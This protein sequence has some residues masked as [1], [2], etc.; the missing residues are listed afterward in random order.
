[1]KKIIVCIWFLSLIPTAQAQDC[2]A[3]RFYQSGGK[4]CASQMSAVKCVNLDI[5]DSFDF[6]GLEMQFI[7]DMGDGQEE[8]GL[9]IQHCYEKAGRYTA[10]LTVID[11]VTKVVMK[12]ELQVD[13][14][15]RGAFSLTLNEANVMAGEPFTPEYELVYPENYKVKSYYWSYGD[16]RFSCDANPEITYPA[17]NK[18]PLVFN[19]ELV[20]QTD[21]VYLCEQMEIDAKMPDPTGGDLASY[22][23][24]LK[25]DSR[26][27]EDP[28]QFHILRETDKGFD[29]VNSI[30]SIGSGANHYLLVFKGNRL[31]RSD[32]FQVDASA[33]NLSKNNVL[34]AAA[35][36]A[37][38]KKPTYLVPVFFELNTS[39]FSKKMKKNLSRNIDILNEYPFLSVMIGC[40]TH[41]G[42]SF[43]RNIELSRDRSQLIKSYMVAEGIEESRLV[44]GDPTAQRSLINTCV[45]LGCDYEEE[46][47]NRRAD[48]KILGLNNNQ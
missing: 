35:N 33:T 17:S 30:D 13:V 8:N 47:L 6:D 14:Y 31:M 44:L 18:F 36:S 48:F 23:N 9:E 39:G 15:I 16:G 34:K 26:F 4:P 32:A 45:T 37:L 27:L 43:S 20:N 19:V 38:N 40:Y 29:Q 3:D 28:A 10:S 2:A 42:G 22:F 21:L 25:S 46:A 12:D 41:T 5:T 24:G 11:E 1:M 7:W